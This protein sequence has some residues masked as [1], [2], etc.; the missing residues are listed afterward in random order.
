MGGFRDPKYPW[1][2]I[3]I[4]FIG[5]FPRSKRGNAWI[6]TVV[7]LFSKYVKAFPLRHSTAELLIDR[8]QNEIFYVHGVPQTLI[9]DNGTPRQ[10]A[11]ESYNKVIG[12]A[13][14]MYINDKQ[15]DRW[16][17]NF[18]EILCAINTGTNTQTNYSPYEIIYGHSMILNGKHHSTVADIN[19]QCHQDHEIKL[20]ILW[21]EMR[22]SLKEAHTR[23]AKQYNKNADPNLS[24]DTGEIVLKRN[25]ILSNKSEKKTSKLLKKYVKCII[26]GKEGHNMYILG[27]INTQ[28]RIGVFSSDLLKKTRQIIRNK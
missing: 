1:R 2:L 27:D 8:L 24:Y 3:A 18:N 17:E 12:T 4:D 22:K 6:L 14:K 28:K 10:N 9:C 25:T 7:D 16:D 20:P 11:S 23:A 13:L 26:L 21:A 15:H 5:P 19:D